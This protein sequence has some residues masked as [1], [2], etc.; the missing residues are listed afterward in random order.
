MA[1]RSKAKEIRF[2]GRINGV[3][4]NYYVIQGSVDHKNRDLSVQKGCEKLGEGVNF[5]TFWVCT[6]LLNP[7]W[8]ELPEVTKAQV[9]TARLIKRAFVG[10]LEAEVVS[11]PKFEG[12]EKHYVMVIIIF[13]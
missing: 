3:H 13:S 7:D 4:Q 5:Y 10:D 6:D 1:E 2:W 9:K 8:V 11:Y 12:K